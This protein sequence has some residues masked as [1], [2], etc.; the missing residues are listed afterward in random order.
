MSASPIGSTSADLYDFRV[1]DTRL[2]L[3]QTYAE[4]LPEQSYRRVR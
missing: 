3:T 4:G 2:V 1:S